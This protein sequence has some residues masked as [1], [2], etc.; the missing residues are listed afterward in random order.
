[1]IEVL[2]SFD[3]EASVLRSV[4]VSGHAKKGEAGYSTVCAAVSALVRTAGRTIESKGSIPIDGTADSPGRLRFSLGEPADNEKADLLW[5]QGV[6]EYFITG[7]RDIA[8]EHPDQCRVRVFA[9]GDE[10]GT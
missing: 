7:I 2:V 10:Y 3:N 8:S 4:E 5:L 6:S 9:E 1:M